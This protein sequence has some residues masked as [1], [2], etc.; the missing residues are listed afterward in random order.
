MTNEALTLERIAVLRECLRCAFFPNRVDDK[1]HCQLSDCIA[2]N[3]D[4]LA[5]LDAAP[6]TSAEPIQIVFD[7]PPGPESGRF[8]EV[9]QGGKSICFGD[10]VLLPTGYWALQFTRALLAAPKVVSRD[11]IRSLLHGL[12]KGTSFWDDQNSNTIEKIDHVQR[13][14]EIVVG[15]IEVEPEKP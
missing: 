12:F 15:G 10:W 4:L 5:L 14:L 13:W 1:S 3:R 8:V 9:E 2:A 6:P 7:G 11:M